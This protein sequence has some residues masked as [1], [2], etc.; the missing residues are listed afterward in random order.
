MKTT[1]TP[2]DA[3]FKQF[4]TRQETARDF[5]DIHLPPAPAENL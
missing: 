2:H 5:L 3:L 1:S 4:M